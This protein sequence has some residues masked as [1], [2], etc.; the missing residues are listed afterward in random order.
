MKMRN[1]SPRSHSYFRDTAATAAAVAL[2]FENGLSLK[3]GLNSS[4]SV[5]Y[6]HRRLTE[7]HVELHVSWTMENRW[8]LVGALLFVWE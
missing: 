4:V 7:V 2:W 8:F 1:H 6:D 5:M 3:Y